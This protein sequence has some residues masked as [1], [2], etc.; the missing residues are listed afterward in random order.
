MKIKRRKRRITGEKNS[1]II[2]SAAAL[3]FPTT[4]CMIRLTLSM[5]MGYST[6]HFRKE[7]SPFPN[8][9]RKL[10]FLKPVYSF[11]FEII[12]E[13]ENPLPFGGGFFMVRNGIKIIPCSNM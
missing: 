2:H 4:A 12:L 8:Q 11:F 10:R 6:S 5:R 3:L 9:K 1:L 13:R 7:K